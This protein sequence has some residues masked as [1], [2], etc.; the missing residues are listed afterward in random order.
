MK[1]CYIATKLRKL[2]YVHAAGETVGGKQKASEEELADQPA[3]RY[4][5]SSPS[6]NGV[7]PEGSQ[8][9]P[10]PA[11][12]T[13][14]VIATGLPASEQEA[15]TSP[16]PQDSDQADPSQCLS[17]A[18]SVTH[19]SAQETQPHRPDKM[20]HTQLQI[21]DS[22]IE[23]TQAQSSAQD[24]KAHLTPQAAK[25]QDEGMPDQAMPLPNGFPSEQAPHT[26]GAE[27][28]LSV[29]AG[30]CQ[31]TDP[32]QVQL[33]DQEPSPAQGQLPDQAEL[34]AAM[35]DADATSAALAEEEAAAA[36]TAAVTH[37]GHTL[38]QAADTGVA[39]EANTPAADVAM[40]DCKLVE[41]ALPATETAA[42]TTAVGDPNQS[43]QAPVSVPNGD[44][45][46]PEAAS[47]DANVLG[48]ANGDAKDTDALT[49]KEVPVPDGAA[50]V[51]AAT[52]NAEDADGQTKKEG[53]PKPKAKQGDKGAPGMRSRRRFRDMT[54]V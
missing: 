20:A 14:P 32:H 52:N 23:Q 25:E 7:P 30:K 4:R 51:P 15:L 3:K 13:A 36:D 41:P 35:A 29:V 44:A 33:P 24:S 46:V 2:F 11:A 22:G 17:S 5:S 54:R 19:D 18:Q 10:A 48:T 9:C 39:E 16:Q 34:D 21:S 53:Q 50:G 31:A 47:G 37:A 26:N 42:P 49:K 45:S 1:G 28:G 27:H 38:Q 8:H 6:P 40:E 12:E 43:D